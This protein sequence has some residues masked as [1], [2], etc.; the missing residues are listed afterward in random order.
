MAWVQSV[1]SNASRQHS[2]K[3]AISMRDGR[4][5]LPSRPVFD[6]LMAWDWTDRREY[7]LDRFDCDDFAAAVMMNFRVKL[8]LNCLAYVQS[9]YGGHAFNLVIFEN[10]TWEW[11]EPQTDRYVRPGEGLY[12][13]RQIRVEM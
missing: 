2:D 8:G 1:I 5:W 3:F 10:G 11:L 6:F 9:Y 12:D 4:Y 7:E 13:M